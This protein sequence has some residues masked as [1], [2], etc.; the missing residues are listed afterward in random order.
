MPYIYGV[1]P[2]R[3]Y[4]K[5]LP[6]LEPVRP[7]ITLAKLRRPARV[8]IR[9]RPFTATLG[10]PLLLPSSAKP[11]YIALEVSPAGEFAAL[12]RMLEAA[13]PGLIEERHGEFRPHLTLYAVRIKRPAE[14]ELEPAVREAEALVGTS[15]VVDEICLIDTAGGEYKVLSRVAL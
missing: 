2:P 6:G 8:E 3:L 10:R 13:L 12:R 1:L 9:Y 11:R 15:F 14:E 5:P 4:V 7:H